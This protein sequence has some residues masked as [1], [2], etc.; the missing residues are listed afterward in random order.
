MVSV[1]GT[2]HWRSSLS[3]FSIEGQHFLCPPLPPPREEADTSLSSAVMVQSCLCPWGEA[4]L[5]PAASLGLPLQAPMQL[6]IVATRGR[7][8]SKAQACWHFP[9]SSCQ[10]LPKSKVHPRPEQEVRQ[11][12][13]GSKSTPAGVPEHSPTCTAY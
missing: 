2:G 7:R 6:G 3:L 10:S 4:T 5:A 13:P 8:N 11:G 9:K 12:L 1:G